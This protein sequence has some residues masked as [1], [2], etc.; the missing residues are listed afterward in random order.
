MTTR[1]DNSPHIP[2][3]HRFA[4]SGPNDAETIERIKGL[5]IQPFIFDLCACIPDLDAQMDDNPYAR[6]PHYQRDRLATGRLI[7][8]LGNAGYSAQGIPYWVDR[9]KG[10]PTIEQIE[11]LALAADACLSTLED[12][13]RSLIQCGNIK[14]GQKFTTRFSKFNEALNEFREM[15]ENQK[16]PLTVKEYLQSARDEPTRA[17]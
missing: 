7:Q 13:Q 11:Q 1:L 17:R 16:P 4:L 6:G 3:T 12:R 15:V 10:E 2:L 14:E 9:K 8:A 5:A